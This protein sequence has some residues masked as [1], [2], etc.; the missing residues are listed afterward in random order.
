MSIKDKAWDLVKWQVIKKHLG[1]TKDEMETFKSNPRNQAVVNKAPEINS[2]TIIAQVVKSHGCNSKH[3]V[4]DKIVFDGA[5]NLLTSKCPK[6]VCAYALSAISPLIFTSNEL[7]YAG[8]DPNEMR[9]KRTSCFDV[10][11]ECGG[12]GQVVF[13][14]KVIDRKQAKA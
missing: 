7:I 9:F 8:I 5:G 1:Y 12:W 13:E 4:G 10:G 3:L 11:L 2:K 6:K 14:L